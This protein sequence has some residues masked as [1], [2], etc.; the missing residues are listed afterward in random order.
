M[1][2]DTLILYYYD[3]ISSAKEKSDIA[4]AL[5]ADDELAA[6]YAELCR[7]LDGLAAGEATAPSHVVQRMHDT[8]DRIAKPAPE[9][10]AAPR[11]SFNPFSFM[12]GAA[13][14]AAL[15]IGIGIGVFFATPAEQ[16]VTA[17]GDPFTRGM[18][19]YL[20]D[21]SDGL[22]AMPVDNPDER[23]RLILH[24]VDQ[25]R[26]FQQAAVHNDSQ[27]LARVLRAFEPILLQLAADDVTPE[28]AEYLRAQLAFELNV[29]LTKLSQAS[30]NEEQTT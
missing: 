10:T 13:V 3:E 21:A 1:N 25:N 2:D 16:P 5:A 28:K 18:Q 6:R 4:A 14:T 22:A 20:K 30:S 29:M 23:M 26:L 24:I 15:A 11:R 9:R 19:V 17:L 12:W 7:D 27:D 8:I